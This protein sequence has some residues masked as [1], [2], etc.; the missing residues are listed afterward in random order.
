MNG[1]TMAWTGS[2]RRNLVAAGAIFALAACGEEEVAPEAVEGEV[3]GMTISDARL[4]LPPVA[5]NP[6]A[7]YFDVD[8][9][10]E[11]GISISGAEVEGAQNAE[12]H[13]MM[14]YDFEMTMAQAAPIALTRGTQVSFE[15]GGLHVMAFG[16]P[17]TLAAGDDVTVTLKISGGDRHRFDAAVRKAGE[18]R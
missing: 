8:Y 3:P 9:D 1:E 12:V 17:D 18:E 2:W 16:L 5:G 7:V 15:P 14:E 4:V 13:D 11:R 6:A 10:G